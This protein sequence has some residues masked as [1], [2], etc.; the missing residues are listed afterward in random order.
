MIQLFVG[1][2]SF[3]L[4]CFSIVVFPLQGLGDCFI[5]W[6]N[7]AAVNVLESPSMHSRSYV[8][9]DSSSHSL[10]PEQIAD[11]DVDEDEE[12]H[13]RT[14]QIEHDENTSSTDRTNSVD[15]LHHVLANDYSEHNDDIEGI[16]LNPMTRAF[17]VD[18]SYI[19]S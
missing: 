2:H 1:V 10:P 5:F 18:S 17:N 9:I 12:E 3:W 19:S 8:N 7:Q 16:M 6:L 4:L 15:H 13:F 14:S 11:R